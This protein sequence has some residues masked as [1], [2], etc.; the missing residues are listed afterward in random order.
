MYLVQLNGMTVY[1][2]ESYSKA[3]HVYNE[4]LDN[5]KRGDF[6]TIW[7][8]KDMGM[9]IYKDKNATLLAGVRT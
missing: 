5:A 8:I 2:D 1:H 3:V 7:F 6:V 9:S 4:K